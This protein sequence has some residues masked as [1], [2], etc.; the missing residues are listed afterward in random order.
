MLIFHSQPLCFSRSLLA[1]WLTRLGEHLPVPNR[2]V[3]LVQLGSELNLHF[4]SA[5][6]SLR[7][8]KEN[9]FPCPHLHWS[10]QQLSEVTPAPRS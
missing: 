8:C 9:L 5:V 4:R 7:L 2:Q 6:M 1:I 3:V 10:C